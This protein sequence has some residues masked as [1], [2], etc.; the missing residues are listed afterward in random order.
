MKDCGD[1][2]KQTGI[3]LWKR[4][5]SGVSSEEVG[6]GK[7]SG[8]H[9]YRR[10]GTGTAGEHRRGCKGNFIKEGVSSLYCTERLKRQ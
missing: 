4:S 6:S 9:G 7:D 2:K 5:A 3:D 10:E 8:R 1:R